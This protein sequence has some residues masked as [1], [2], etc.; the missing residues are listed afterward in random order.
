LPSF[1]LSF[2]FS[3]SIAL[4]PFSQPCSFWDCKGGSFFLPRQ[5]VFENSLK[6]L[7]VLGVSLGFPFETAFFS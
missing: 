3:C 1:S 2:Q 6:Q 7:D 4:L 5:A